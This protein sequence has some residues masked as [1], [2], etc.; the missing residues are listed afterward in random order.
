MSRMEG[1]LL[2]MA[3]AA[4]ARQENVK[5]NNNENQLSHSMIT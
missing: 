4:Q 1:R 5:T 2:D 3:N